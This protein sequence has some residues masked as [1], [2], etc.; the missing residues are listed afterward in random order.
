MS[1][2]AWGKVPSL[3]KSPA[4]WPTDSPRRMLRR[5][6]RA[7]RSLL[8]VAG[9]SLLIVAGIILVVIVVG[10][11]LVPVILYILIYYL[12]YLG[13]FLHWFWLPWQVGLG[14]VGLGLLGALIVL[15]MILV[16]LSRW[17]ANRPS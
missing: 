9:I 17:W 14:L 1:L 4:N 16:Y 10:F 2:S 11:Y 5:M 6:E 7:L 8:T 13:E 3:G 12:F 15:V